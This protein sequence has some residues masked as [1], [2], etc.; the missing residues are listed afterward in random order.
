MKIIPV[1]YSLLLSLALSLLSACA[2]SSGPVALSA[3]NINL[4][5]VVSPDLAHN[6]S[7]DV[8]QDT[9]NLSNQGLQRSLLLASYLK[10]QVLG[11]QNAR[12]IHALTPMTHLQTA[13]NYPD[14]AAL[15]YIQQFALLNQISL[16]VDKAGPPYTANSYPLNA[17]YAPGSVP[18]GVAVPTSYCADCKGLVFNDTKDNNAALVSDIINKPNASGHY[19]FSAPWD[20]TSAML[21][22]INKLYG[23][24]LTLPTRYVDPNHVYA[25]SINPS[26]SASLV[27][28]DSKLNPPATYPVLP[29]HQSFSA[30]CTYTQ[31]SYFSTA[32]AAGVDGAVVPA[33]SST[34]QTIYIIRHA[35]AHPDTGMKFEDGNFVGAGQWR[36]LD[37]PN[38]L[39]N[40]ISRPDMVYSV[41]PAQW[42]SIS[43]IK[44]VSYVR[45]S[46]TVL[47]Y[48][49][50]N[51]L[52]FF[53]VSS[54]S[55]FDPSQSQLTSDFFFTGGKFSNKTVLV[56][57][58]SGR[59][60]PLINAL[61]NSYGGSSLPLLSPT[62]WPSAD[63][64]TIWTVKLDASGNLTVDNAL[65]EGIDSAKLPV[66]APQF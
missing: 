25:V 9:A 13:N 11:T 7:G 3:D 2:G 23:S 41:D 47:P 16:P 30:S 8:N 62:T 12:A 17:A 20:T 45:P 52:P 54:F 53:L 46:L 38:A 27:T 64:D 26:G 61:L 58:E 29:S 55:L 48:A 37:L 15:G 63:Y 6:V 33:N 28:Y 43:T 39:Q 36:A 14:M 66:T 35:E 50:A 10:Q 24:S 65:C 44:N 31:Q 32:R 57:W 19:V 22:N 18:D 49:V 21:A 34:N 56:A 40:K 1:V 4:I 5:F 51:N 42:Y 59:I 60:R